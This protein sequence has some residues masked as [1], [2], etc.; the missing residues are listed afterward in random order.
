MSTRSHFSNPHSPSPKQYLSVTHVTPHHQTSPTAPNIL[1]PRRQMPLLLM[2]RRPSAK[3]LSTLIRGVS[4]P[5]RPQNPATTFLFTV[6]T[7]S[8][9]SFAPSS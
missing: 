6:R 5:P 1:N 2:L 7:S 9:S 4:M 3:P 8:S